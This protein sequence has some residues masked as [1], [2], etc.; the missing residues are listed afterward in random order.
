MGT[1]VVEISSKLHRELKIIAA[2]EGKT[3]RTVMDEALDEWLAEKEK[4]GEV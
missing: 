2:K 4:P 3:L 1:K